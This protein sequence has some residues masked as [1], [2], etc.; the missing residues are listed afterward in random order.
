MKILTITV[1]FFIS[2]LTF[3]EESS[4]PIPVNEIV[5]IKISAQDARA[6]IK[7]PGEKLRMIQT[8]D[9]IGARAKV[10]EIA[11]ERVVIE[12]LTDKGTE[13]VIIRFKDGQQSVERI[14]S[15]PEDSPQLYVPNQG[16]K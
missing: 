10:I 4:P 9:E 13:T 12:E 8:G 11:R 7:I 3:A 1:I 6:V 2:L 14:R 16:G 5:V 15:V